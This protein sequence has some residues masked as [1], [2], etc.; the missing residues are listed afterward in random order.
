MPDR[1]GTNEWRGLLEQTRHALSTLRAEDLE[2]LAAH[3]ERVFHATS[4]SEPESQ[5]RPKAR[6]QLPQPEVAT[7]AREHHLLSELLLA[8]EKNIEVLRILQSRQPGRTP[9]GELNSRWVR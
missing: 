9:A 5:G 8:T 1:L 2:A 6:P 4:C 7:L 3:T